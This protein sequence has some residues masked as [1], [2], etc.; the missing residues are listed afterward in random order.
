MV[1]MSAIEII[2]ATKEFKQHRVLDDVTLSFGPNKIHGII[3]RNGSGKT[4]L[5]KAI[6]GFIPLTSGR[7]LVNGQQIGKDISSPNDV[8]S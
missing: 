7:V 6:C 5:F 4:L 2:A 3:G 8:E 1:D